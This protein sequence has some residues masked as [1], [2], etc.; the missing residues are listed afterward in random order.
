[1]EL[2][3]SNLDIAVFMRIIKKQTKPIRNHCLFYRLKKNSLWRQR[4]FL[5]IK[6]L[7]IYQI[8]DIILEKDKPKTMK[9]IRL[10]MLHE[11]DQKHNILI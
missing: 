7:G 9:I 1:M 4:T 2:R 8:F 10:K 6:N 11:Y 5:I 3:G